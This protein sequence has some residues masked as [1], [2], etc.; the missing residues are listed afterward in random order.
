[1]QPIGPAGGRSMRRPSLYERTS[2]RVVLGG[3][4][5]GL[6][7][8]LVVHTVKAA[9]PR[10]SL[11]NE[12]V[13][14]QPVVDATPETPKPLRVAGFIAHEEATNF[15]E[16]AFVY[17][18]PPTPQP[19]APV[20]HSG[21]YKFVAGEGSRKGRLIAD[22]MYGLRRRR[23]QATARLRQ[24]LP[25]PLRQVRRLLAQPHPLRLRLWRRRPLDQLWQ[26]CSRSA[27]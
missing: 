26:P 17:I 18:P 25:Q 19:L 20:F 3:L 9:E 27:L 1:M 2:M 13:L 16:G 12:P 5:V 4:L 7:M 6:A 21:K 22:Q 10:R 23:R 11:P 14:E 24:P 15:H 8:T